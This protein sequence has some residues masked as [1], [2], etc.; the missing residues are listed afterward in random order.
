MLAL[1]THV[2]PFCFLILIDLR[3]YIKNFQ[4]S[5]LYTEQVHIFTLVN[6]NIF[7]HTAQLLQIFQLF[8][9]NVIK[10]RHQAFRITAGKSRPGK[11]CNKEEK[12]FESPFVIPLCALVSS[13]LN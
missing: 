8:S 5:A 3:K 7:L 6:Q 10:M 12:A 4:S 9:L 13:Q 11:R 2:M 1:D